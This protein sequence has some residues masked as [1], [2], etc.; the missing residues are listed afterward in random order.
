MQREEALTITSLPLEL[1]A[2]I[3]DQLVSST[4]E[5]VE[6]DD[7]A[8]GGLDLP[9]NGYT[10][11]TSWDVMGEDSA[12][13]EDE[14]EDEVDRGSGGNESK[15]N[16]RLAPSAASRPSMEAVEAVLV[17]SAVCS[18]WREVIIKENALWKRV[19]SMNLPPLACET[20]WIASSI[21][22]FFSIF[23]IFLALSPC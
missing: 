7:R 5:D 4:T 2:A 14:E 10:K 3:F 12:C 17:A 1:L 11:G 6:C 19:R 9:E 20:H 18:G 15:E 13:T 21:C 16:S 22:C 23:S 8:G